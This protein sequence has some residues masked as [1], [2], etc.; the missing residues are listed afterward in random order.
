[1]GKIIEPLKNLNSCANPTEYQ[2][3]AKKGLPLDEAVPRYLIVNN[4]RT[5]YE[6]FFRFYLLGIQLDI[7]QCEN[8]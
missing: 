3:L 7:M 4:Y 1:M 6:D 8:S 2:L 5:N